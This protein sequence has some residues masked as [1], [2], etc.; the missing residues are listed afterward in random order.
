MSLRIDFRAVTLCKVE[1]IREA[2]NRLC[3]DGPFINFCF[4]CIISFK[5]FTIEF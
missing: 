2:N 1:I 4:S 3:R 5:A